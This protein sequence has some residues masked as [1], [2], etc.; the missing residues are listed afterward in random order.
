MEEFAQIKSTLDKKQRER[1]QLLGKKSSIIEPLKLQGFN[2]IEDAEVA[3]KK[4]DTEI[5]KMEDDLQDNISE[6]KEK[7]KDLL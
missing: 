7:Y 5:E 3:L 4:I 2:T 6:F 1:D